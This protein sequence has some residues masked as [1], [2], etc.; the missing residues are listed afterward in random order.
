MPTRQAVTHLVSTHHVLGLE[1]CIGLNVYRGVSVKRSRLNEYTISYSIFGGPNR[2]K[3]EAFS[4]VGL[5][6]ARRRSGDLRAQ[7]SLGM[8]RG[9]CGDLSC[10]LIGTDICRD[11]SGSIWMETDSDIIFYHILNRIQMQIFA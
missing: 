4:H 1:P 2:K 8:E 7:P 5:V 9:G 6:R 10:L 3:L 11:G